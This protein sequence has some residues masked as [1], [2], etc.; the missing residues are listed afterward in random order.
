ML[1]HHHLL[2][3]LLPSIVLA[4][5]I[6]PKN[7]PV[8]QVDGRSYR[9]LIERSN[10]TSIV[11]F[12]APWCGHC[13]NLKPAYEKAAK[14]LHG[15]AKVAAVNCDAEENK[16]F[17]GSMGVQGFPTLKIVRPGKKAGRPLVEDYQGARTAKGI[18]D[19]VVSQIPNHVKRLK[20]GE[21]EA[22]LEEG[23]EGPKA[24]LFSEKGT[25]SALLKAVAVDFLGVMGVAQIRDREKEAV[26][27]FHVEKFPTLVLLPGE[28]TDP[29]YYEGEMKKEPMIAFLSQAAQPNPD[30]ALKKERP[31][32]ASST[33]KSKASKASSS[34]SKAS[35][36]HASADSQSAK[37]SQ[38][39]ET[40]DEA[41]NP[42]ASPHPNVVDENT[43]K[44]VKVP[45]LAPPIS[46]LQDG[47][48][49]QQKCLNSKAGTCILA[50]LPE[51]PGIKTIQA[52][53]SLS[54]IHHKHE[55]AKRNLFPF[56]Q[57]PSSNSQAAALRSKLNLGE[58][59]E[60]IAING[61]RRWY[62]HYTPSSLSQAD[63]ENWIDAIRMGDLPKDSLPAGLIADASQLP[64]EPV[65]LDVPGA[66]PME[67]MRERMKG[68]LPE[69]V[70]FEMEE[71]GDE[72]YERI[73][74]AQQQQAPGAEGEGA[75]DEL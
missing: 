44:P 65:K 51:V 63:L 72:E 67:E 36:S 68:Q 59:V 43:P 75:H 30:P 27:V 16:P 7:S 45:D 46:S 38:T 74:A 4:N 56:Y 47:L 61:K 55:Q 19:A 49:L 26:E 57:L 69:G 15:L 29:V 64:Q 58:D 25:T 40:L 39:A 31:A 9:D 73:M 11:E 62:R 12:Y 52:I 1:P 22:W 32:K 50:L 6:Y 35:A 5:G 70:E 24:I 48:S 17:C 42:I 71:V 34:F 14:S 37:A 10:H 20:D 8:I 54:E 2:L 41:S 53:S 33:N 18:V 13:Q 21:Y 66:N 3:T 23:A 28:G 60:L